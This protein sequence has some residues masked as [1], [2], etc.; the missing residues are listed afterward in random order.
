MLWVL[1]PLTAARDEAIL[2]ARVGAEGK[3]PLG[4]LSSLLQHQSLER[5]DP[6]PVGPTLAPGLEEW[7]R[8]G[9]SEP[10]HNAQHT[11]SSLQ[12]G[13]HI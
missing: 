9:C 1:S 8:E 6:Q 2:G 5:H 12:V 11:E 4:P 10:L 3:E 13:R 7:G